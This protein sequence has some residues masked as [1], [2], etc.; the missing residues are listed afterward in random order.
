M[1]S[2]WK[3]IIIPLFKPQ[4]SKG[5]LRLYF[6]ENK[7]NSRG[8]HCCQIFKTKCSNRNI[9]TSLT[10][11]RANWVSK[12]SENFKEL[13]FFGLVHCFSVKIAQILKNCPKMSFFHVFGSILDVFEDFSVLTE[14]QRTKP[15]NL[16]SLKF[17]A[18]SDP[19]FDPKGARLVERN[20]SGGKYPCVALSMVYKQCL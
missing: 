18:S 5:G 19:Q 4:T 12:E 10:P 15:K 3:S 6:E 13:N 16:S 17:S 2:Y 1:I 8:H 7:K 14:K 9:S 11:L 20:D